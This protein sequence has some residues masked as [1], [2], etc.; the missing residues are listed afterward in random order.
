[1]IARHD[2]QP[3]AILFY[4]TEATGFAPPQ[5]RPVRVVGMVHD[6][7]PRSL[8]VGVNHDVP[9]LDERVHR[10]YKFAPMHL[11]ATEAEAAL[12]C[13]AHDLRKAHEREHRGVSWVAQALDEWRY[14]REIVEKEVRDY[15]VAHQA[16]PPAGLAEDD[17]QTAEDRAA[18][19][20]F[21]ETAYREGVLAERDRVLAL[22]ESSILEGSAEDHEALV[23]HRA[24]YDDSSLEPVPDYLASNEA[25]VA[26]HAVTT[27]YQRAEADRD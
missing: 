1:M 24:P 23:K 22:L 3:G 6:W 20:H 17:P 7:G 18:V 11:Y 8:C 19:A 10:V 14:S 9:H 13:D 27:A 21:H 15:T 2:V 16:P 25:V 26:A 5:V 12:V 4:V